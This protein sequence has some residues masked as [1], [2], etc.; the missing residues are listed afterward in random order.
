MQTLS[1]LINKLAPKRVLSPYGPSDIQP[2]IPMVIE[3]IASGQTR[4]LNEDE[5]GSLKY[6]GVC[7]TSI[8]SVIRM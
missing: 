2:T 3:T 5:I 6:K 7:P 4:T 8:A 1:A